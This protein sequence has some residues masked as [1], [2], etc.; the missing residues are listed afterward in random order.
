M[1]TY[2]TD[3][4]YNSIYT[5]KVLLHKYN[6]HNNVSIKHNTNKL[7]VENKGSKEDYGRCSVQVRGE[8]R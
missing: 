6:K 7:Y 3:S 8:E 5:W 1:K 4:K 2:T